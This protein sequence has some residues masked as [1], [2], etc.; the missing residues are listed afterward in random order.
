MKA[1]AWLA[2]FNFAAVPNWHPR[3]ECLKTASWQ[4]PGAL[5]QR[6]LADRLNYSL[7][8]QEYI[9]LSGQAK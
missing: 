8:N 2:A 7:R 3:E 1:K 5:E 4:F 9:D 6:T